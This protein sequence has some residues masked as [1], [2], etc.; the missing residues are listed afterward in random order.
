MTAIF[1]VSAVF[2]DN[3]SVT[4]KKYVDDLMSGYQGKLPGSGANK[5]MIYDDETGIGEK[6]IV[7][8]LGNSASATTVPTVGAVKTGLDGKQ[9]TINGTPG[10][11]MTGTGT[12]GEV[13]ERAI[14]SANTNY[15]DSLVTA[16]TVNTGVINA[17]N[18]SL[19]RVNEQGTPSD[20]GTLWEI[21]TSLF[22]LN[23]RPMLPD[24]Y[25][26]RQY[27]YMMEGSYIKVEDLPISAGYKVEFDFQT[28]ATLGSN[29]RNY[30]GGRSGGSAGGGFRLSKLASGGTTLNRVVLYGFESGTEYYDPTTQFQPNTRYKY[31]YDNGVCTLESGGSVVSTQTFTVTDNTSTKWG[32]NAYVNGTTWQT[33]SS[34][35][36]VYSVKVWNTQGELVMNLVPATY[37][38]TVGFYDTVSKTFKTATS[39]TFTAGPSCISPNLINMIPANITVGKYIS[40]QGVVSDSVSNFI[41][42]KYIPVKPNT[43]YTLSFNNEL[44]FVTMSEYSSESDAGFIKRTQGSTGGNTSLTITTGATTQYLRWGSNP[45]GNDN[46]VTLEQI[47]AINWMLTEGDTAQTYRPYGEN[48]CY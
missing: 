35:I 29:L 44:Y 19:I 9:D 21:N 38:N 46:E 33:N 41:Y 1:A 6:E 25:I 36:Y 31:T 17:V 18:S 48:I 23:V 8:T 10:Y 15:S 3:S 20:S 22:A 39:G 26:Q 45:Y 24:G 12:P 42:N 14:Y 43:K 5:L 30:L 32:I 13:G 16:E 37:N 40:A 4:S 34:D 47:Q 2:A 27:I 11:V 28:T 7:S